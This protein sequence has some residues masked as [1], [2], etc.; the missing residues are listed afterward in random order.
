MISDEHSG[1]LDPRMFDV[2]KR[3]DIASTNSDLAKGAGF[4]A[5][6]AASAAIAAGG[7]NQVEC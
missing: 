1:E 7:V 2:L 3:A 6:T 4:Y 5:V